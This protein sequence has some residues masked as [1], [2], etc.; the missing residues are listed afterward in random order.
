LEQAP[1]IDVVAI[2]LRSGEV[3]LHNLKFNETVVKFQQDWG[4]VTGVAFRTDDMPVM[5]TGSP[6]GHVAVWDLEGRKL[7]LQMR[8]CHEGAVTGL[9]CLAGE[10]I[11]AAPVDL[12][13][14][15]Q[16][17]LRRWEGQGAPP[18]RLRHYGARGKAFRVFSTVTDLL[19]R[20]LGHSSFDRKR[21][22]KH[23]VAED[24]L[25]MP[26]IVDLT[27]DTCRNR[28][29][30]NIACVHHGKMG[31]LQLLH[32]RFKLEPELHKVQQRIQ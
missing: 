23:W 31:E 28:E 32:D 6:A 15:G 29:W 20:S 30:D 13:H 17:E 26:P 27:T 7:A 24:P 1:A 14:V 3:F 9:R 25:R 16:R 2:G 21:S 12:R 18:A 4:P 10:P 5:V 11:I 8:S 22:R 19:H